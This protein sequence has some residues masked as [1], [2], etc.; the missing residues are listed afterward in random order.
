MQIQETGDLYTIHVIKKPKTSIQK[1]NPASGIYDPSSFP[2]LGF[3][4]PWRIG[5][6]RFNAFH[7]SPKVPYL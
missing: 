5:I 6:W 4:S 1:N 3:G 2:D 7:S